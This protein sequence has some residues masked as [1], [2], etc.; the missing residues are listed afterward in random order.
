MVAAADGMVNSCGNQVVTSVYNGIDD[1][2]WRNRSQR[3]VYFTK[4]CLNPCPLKSSY[5]CKGQGGGVRVEMELVL[6]LCCMDNPCTTFCGAYYEQNTMVSVFSECLK[7][8]RMILKC[9]KQ[10]N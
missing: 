3:V 7:F 4:E 9:L 2:W 8:G 1:C 6:V 10:S 5:K